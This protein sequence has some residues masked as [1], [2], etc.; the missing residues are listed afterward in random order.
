MFAIIRK[1]IKMKEII[2]YTEQHM[3]YFVKTLVLDQII[4]DF[5]ILNYEV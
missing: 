4:M 3:I 2:R 5:T 1:S